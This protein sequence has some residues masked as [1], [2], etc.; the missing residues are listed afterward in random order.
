LY[1]GKFKGALTHWHYD[2]FQFT[3]QAPDVG[4]MRVTFTLNGAGKVD[5]LKIQG[6]ADFKRVPEQEVRR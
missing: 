5:E 1:I 2:T 3:S 6:L 4:K